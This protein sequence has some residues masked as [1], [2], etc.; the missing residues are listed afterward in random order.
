MF[1]V[2]INFLAILVCGFVY[3]VIGMV[4][5]GPLFGKMWRGLVGLTEKKMEE[6]K[7]KGMAQTYLTSF[8]LSLVMAYVLD[9]F[10][11]FTSPGAVSV[12]IGIKTGI[13]VWVGFVATTGTAGYLYY[14]EK[15]PWMLYVL[16]NGNWLI[17][18]V[19]F[20][21]ILSVWR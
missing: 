13:W 17:N 19:L 12:T 14:A 5:Y 9:H 2:P 4:W 8:L 18:L 20:G 6:I 10:I 7:K 15:K 21:I 1:N 11:W 3:M 16:D